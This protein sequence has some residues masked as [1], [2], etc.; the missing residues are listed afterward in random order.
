[1]EEIMT[2]Q[3]APYG[4]WKSPISAMDVF[5]TYVEFEAIQPDGTDLY[6]SEDRPDGRKVVVRCETNHKIADITPPDYNAHTIVHEYGGGDY[7]AVDG[8]VYFSNFTDQRMYRQ[9]LGTEPVPLTCMENMR[10]ADAVM[11]RE[12]GRIICVREDHTHPSSQAI[13]T[14]VGIDLSTGNE[15]VLISGNDFYSSPRLNPEGTRLAWLTWNHPNMPWD[16]TELWVA[17]IAS[18]GSLGQPKL[19]AGG[20]S[21]SIFQPQWSPDG[22]LYFVSDRTGWWNLYRW[23]ESLLDVEAIH[24]MQAEFGKPQWRFGMS[25]YAFASADQLICAYWQNGV[26]HLASLDTHTL[27]FKG[28]DLPYTYFNDIQVAPGQAYFIAGSATKPL[29]LV[30]FNLSKREIT[31]LRS[32]MAVTIDPTYF[33]IPQSIEFPTDGGLSAYGFYYPP[34][35]PGFDGLIDTLPPLI[36]K[37]HGGPTG[38]TYSVLN[39]EIQYWTTRGFA[40]LDVNYG[41]S[42]GYGR[43][44]RERLKGQW[45]LVDVADCVNGARYLGSQGLVDQNQLVIT[46]GSA[47]GY[48]TLCA[49]AFYQLFKAAACYFGISDLEVFVK[50]THKFESRYLESLVGPYPKRQDL[51]ISRS[52]IHYIENITCPLIL[53][54]GL[55]DPIVPPNQSQ[56]IYDA[57]RQRGIPVAYIAFPGER[58]GF[59]NS[60][61]N[62]RALQAELYFYSRIFKFELSEDIEPVIIENL[63]R[64]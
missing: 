40:V 29:A 30:Q 32:S 27:E 3:F 17:R 1:M 41:G 64:S 26:A 2:P 31:V 25:T 63:R 43:P 50:D 18:N 42:S 12:H 5:A 9:E 11:D 4:A 21:E 56:M 38:A 35:N 46:G 60:Q 52:P 55:D 54:Q 62:I 34:N 28:I 14:L 47:G 6:W 36:V 15:H 57:V 51:Y 48:V 45:G 24:P 19:V 22:I 59:R 13:N 44:Y 8:V 37:S 53:F 10:Y 23:N 58:H 16:G 49:I 33:S 61:N 7:L 20:V 39:P